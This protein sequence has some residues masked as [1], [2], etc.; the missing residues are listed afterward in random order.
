M[1][2]YDAALEN[3]FCVLAANGMAGSEFFLFLRYLAPDI[4]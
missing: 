3:L 2:I 4:D 1:G